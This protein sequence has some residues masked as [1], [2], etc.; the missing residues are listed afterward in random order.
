VGAQ[1]GVERTLGNRLRRGCDRIRH[2]GQGGGADRGGGLEDAPAR[3]I[4]WLDGRFGS[5]VSIVH[6]LL[7]LLSAW[8]PQRK[9]YPR[10][11]QLETIRNK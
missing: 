10:N 7:L 5:L 3:G 1:L 6:E 2:T 9:Y 8:Q 11:L 4:V